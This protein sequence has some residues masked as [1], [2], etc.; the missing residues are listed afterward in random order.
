[1]Y[2]PLYYIRKYPITRNTSHTISKYVLA[3]TGCLLMSI[4]FSSTASADSVTLHPY[5]M[6]IPRGQASKTTVEPLASD[7]QRGQVDKWDSYIEFYPQSDGMFSI[8]NFQLPVDM[9]GQTLDAVTLKTNFKGPVWDEQPYTWNLRN[10]K[11]DSWVR[12]GTN[13]GIEDWTWAQQTFQAPGN[14]DDFI[15]PLGQMT[16]LFATG[17]SV[18]NSNVDYVALE[19]TTTPVVNEPITPDPVT[20][21][22]ITP[23]PI[24]AEPS[25]VWSPAPEPLGRYSCKVNWTLR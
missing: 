19:V 20:P 22:P 5:S 6:T 12:I 3:V 18:D 16:A 24:V 13:E 21:D 2:P 7:E 8:L 23:D 11:T 1:M 17:S 4:G 15:N 25:E 14:V 9:T 10:F